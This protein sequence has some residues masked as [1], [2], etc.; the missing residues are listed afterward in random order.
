M[1]I[2]YLSEF[3]PPVSRGGGEKSAYLLAKEVAKKN[4]VTVLTSRF[5]GLK[6]V[7]TKD[8]IKILRKLKTGI[9][10]GSIKGN[11]VRQFFFERSLREAVKNHAK[12]F[13][14]IHCLNITT[15][16]AVLE[17][18][19]VKKPFILHVNS[20]ILFCPKG[21]LMYKDKVPCDKNCTPFEFLSCISNSEEIGKLKNSFLLKYNP[22]FLYMI[23]K[24]YTNYMNCLPGFDHF[25]AISNFMKKKLLAKGIEE[26][27]I[28]VVPNIVSFKPLKNKKFKIPKFLYLGAYIKSKGPHLL[29][30]ALKN[31]EF[32]Y[33]C[34]LYGSGRLHAE[35]EEMARSHPIHVH[36]AVSEE[37]LP[38]IY[39]DHNVVVIPS[40]VG[41]AFSRVA[42]EAM[43]A[44]KFIIASDRGGIK[45]VIKDYGYKMIVDVEKELA[46][47]L[48]KTKLNNLQPAKNNEKIIISQIK[49][50]YRTIK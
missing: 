20:P 29:I 27:K 13:D 24:R 14:I 25:M 19:N 43:I 15:A 49:N 21:T 38:K 31:A 36:R 45:D 11:I 6:D 4:D 30:K 50:I 17:K 10:P 16:S 37:E 42:A 35:L 8:G 3:F 40:L 32:K 33:T 12:S 7:E 48:K 39:Q 18:E 28:S 41:E 1:R 22:L 23:R 46:P 26:N 5:K 47:I 9:D 34:D 44:G 2:L